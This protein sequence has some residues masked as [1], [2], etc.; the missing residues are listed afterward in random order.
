MKTR[1][2]HTK[3]YFE[4]DWFYE[5]TVENKFLFI[6]L[7]TNSHIGL[8][9]LYELAE[10]VILSETKL[11]PEDLADAKKVFEQSG[12]IFFYK[13]WI[14]LVNSKKYAQYIGDRNKVASNRELSLI[15]QDVLRYFTNTVSIP[16]TYPID[17][18]INNKPK[19]INQKQGESKK[20]V[21]VDKNTL[22][23]LD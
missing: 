20:F 4:D 5:L 1:I 17:T 7:I 14:Y 18:P 21:V 6:Y 13:D 22:K 3:I 19:I 2:I 8:T 23:E 16:Y 12:K 11:K 15:P 10:R 9:G